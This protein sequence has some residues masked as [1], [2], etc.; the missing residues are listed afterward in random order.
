[1]VLE[2]AAR[3]GI[4]RL[5]WTRDPFR[6]NAALAGGRWLYRMTHTAIIGALSGRARPLL[7]QRSFRCT[8]AVF[9][10]LQN[11]RVDEDILSRLAIPGFSP[12]PQWRD[13]PAN[14]TRLSV[15]T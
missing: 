2:N 15:P 9:D 13:R 5:R 3:W 8:D 12:I 14:S 7:E 4:T 1:M 11:E 6:L 10:L